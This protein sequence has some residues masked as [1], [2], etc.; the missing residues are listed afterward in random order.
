MLQANSLKK[1]LLILFL[2]ISGNKAF[3]QAASYA[4][5]TQLRV[6]H[7]II[8]TPT[9]LSSGPGMDD[10]TFAVSIP[11]FVYNGITY[12]SMYVS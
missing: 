12:T 5:T 9:I 2:A 7:P 4:L 8:N 10:A 6:Y 1:L 3:A 11:A